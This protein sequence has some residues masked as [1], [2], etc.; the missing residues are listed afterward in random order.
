MISAAHD[1][2]ICDSPA[3]TFYMDIFNEILHSHPEIASGLSPSPLIQGMDTSSPAYEFTGMG[4]GFSL[5]SMSNRIRELSCD[6]NE[7]TFSWRAFIRDSQ[8]DGP[9][10]ELSY[11]GGIESGLAVYMVYMDA[12][13]NEIVIAYRYVCTYVCMYV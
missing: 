8:S 3:N 12:A 2:N 5:T 9:L 4:S 7:V 10:I 1:S 13:A 11:S 6:H